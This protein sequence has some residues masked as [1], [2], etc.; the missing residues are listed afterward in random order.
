M[1]AAPEELA[2]RTRAALV[3]ETGAED[4]AWIL[5]RPKEEG[6]M[7][8]APNAAPGVRARAIGSLD[9]LH[10]GSWRN[11]RAPVKRFFRALM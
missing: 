7:T 1:P 6:V 2:R 4:G 5:V 9:R 3:R 11:R 8:S 10:A